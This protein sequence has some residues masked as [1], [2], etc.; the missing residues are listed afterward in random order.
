MR[1]KRPIVAI[2]GPAGSGKS[3]VARALSARLGFLLVDTGALYR[4]VAL[5]AMRRGVS[6]EDEAGA[7]AVA[8]ELVAKRSLR[9]ARSDDGG[10]ALYLDGEDISTAIRTQ[11]VAM[12]ASHVSKFSEVR[13]ALL[14]MQR[15]AGEEGGV[16]LEG[17]DIG[18]VVFP[19]AERKYFLTATPEVRAQRRFAELTAKGEETT[20]EVV[21][22]EVRARDAQDEGRAVAPLRPAEDACVI[23]SSVLTVD[24]VV[25]KIEADVRRPS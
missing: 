8:Q 3:T 16:V 14:G 15:Q 22:G 5:A 20:F 23:D 19:H 4:G 1:P 18:T 12:G 13:Q 7:S 10:F 2:D 11:E 24:E 21:L 17:R 9:M 6:V 25:A